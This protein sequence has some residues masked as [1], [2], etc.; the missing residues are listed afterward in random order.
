MP[1]LNL[2]YYSNVIFWSLLLYFS[3]YSLFT[4]FILFFFS[5]KYKY[6]SLFQRLIIFIVLVNS[7]IIDLILYLYNFCKGVYYSYFIRYNLILML[8]NI[9]NIILSNLKGLILNLVYYMEIYKLNLKSKKQLYLLSFYFLDVPHKGQ[10]FFQDPATPIMEGIINFHHDLLFIQIFIAIF[11]LYMLL[12]TIF[13]Y[14]RQ[15]YKSEN[16]VTVI[17][18]LGGFGNDKFDFSFKNSTNSRIFKALYFKYIY[19]SCYHFQS[20]LNR[21]AGLS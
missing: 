6:S 18:Q 7:K 11:V 17:N 4:Y 2:I 14:S 10:Y 1:Q 8:K 21:E 13:L 3:F 12:I 15:G 9:S 16:Y 20:E 19:Y 5:R